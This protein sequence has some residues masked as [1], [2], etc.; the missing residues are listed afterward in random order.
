MDL[1]SSEGAQVKVAAASPAKDK[2]NGLFVS[3]T[4]EQA[5]SVN[6]L[7]GRI[8]LPL[9][10]FSDGRFVQLT[11]IA[12]HALEQIPGPIRGRTRMHADTACIDEVGL[13][14]V[15]RDASLLR[16][17]SIRQ[18]YILEQRFG[19]LIDAPADDAHVSGITKRSAF[20]LN[21]VF[22]L[23]SMNE[24]MTGFTQGDEVIRA[25]ATRLS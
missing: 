8:A 20:A 19:L 13:L 17:V 15:M 9:S 24:I 22:L 4:I 16:K 1:G 10:A 3:H 21:L 18:L 7:G 5:E 23:C 12:P 14:Q 6:S 25:I 2:T 11:V